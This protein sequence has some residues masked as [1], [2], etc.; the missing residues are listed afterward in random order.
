MIRDVVKLQDQLGEMH[1][2]DVAAA[3]IRDFAGQRARRHAGEGN[4]EASTA[5]G[6]DAYLKDRTDTV[7]RKQTEY[8]TTWLTLTSH[9]WRK[10]LALLIAGVE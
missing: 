5:P 3:L 7:A 10:R 6:L 2:A 1:D 8:E 9:D 4:Q